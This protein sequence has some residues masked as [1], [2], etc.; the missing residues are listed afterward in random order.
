MVG[1]DREVAMGLEGF[2]AGLEEELSLVESSSSFIFV[3]KRLVLKERE[4]KVFWTGEEEEDSSLALLKGFR[5]SASTSGF[6]GGGERL[7]PMDNV[8]GRVYSI[9]GELI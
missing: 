6:G 8:R 3:G 5:L 2:C 1:L 9:W 4:P 7:F